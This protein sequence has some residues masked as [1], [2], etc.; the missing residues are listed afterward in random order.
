[1]SRRIVNVVTAGLVLMGLGYVIAV[2]ARDLPGQDETEPLLDLALPSLHWL[3]AASAW[4]VLAVA[5][6]LAAFLLLNL[7]R[8][9]PRERPR[10]MRW[11]VVVVAV[12]VGYFISVFTFEELES[13]SLALPD[14]D[15]I[16]VVGEATTGAAW[17]VG[18]LLAVVIAAAFV[19]VA[20]LI[21]SGPSIFGP[22][23]HPDD[24]QAVASPSVPIAKPI[25]TSTGSD[26]RSRVINAYAGF[27]AGARDKGAGRRRSET[28]RRH[29]SRVESEL[30]IDSGDLATLS[31]GYSVARFGES[32]VK[33]SD[34]DLVEGAYGRIK[35]SFER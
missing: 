6:G 23:D 8:I 1:M 4:A 21:R 13:G 18:V 16:V 33:V 11:L 3:V 34:A 9:V 20:I 27:E 14:I 26:P 32:V 30:S 29:T 10:S 25:P 5:V 17:V 28:S 22:E 35:K 19:R 15:E 24:N 7:R 31:H 2:S 12:G